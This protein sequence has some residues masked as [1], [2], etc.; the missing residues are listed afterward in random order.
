MHKFTNK[1]L[2][3]LWKAEQLKRILILPIAIG[4]QVYEII[5]TYN[6]DDETAEDYEKQT[7]FELK[8]KEVCGISLNDG[9]WYVIDK[10]GEEILLG[11]DE[12]L[13]PLD[14]AQTIYTKWAKNF[15]KWKANGRPQLYY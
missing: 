7:G 5:R 4:E 8:A 12:A 10:V 11:S 13:Y 2:A 6:Y 3:E 14:H 1:R 9:H 15:E